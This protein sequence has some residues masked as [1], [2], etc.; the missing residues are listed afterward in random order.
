MPAIVKPRSVRIII[1]SLLGV[2]VIVRI[3]DQRVSYSYHTSDK[4][5]V[6]AIASS[7]LNHNHSIP[8]F[9]SPFGDNG[10][11]VEVFE[12]LF[13]LLDRQNY[14]SF[15]AIAIYNIFFLGKFHIMSTV[16]LSS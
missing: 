9:R 1:A 11:I 8:A 12:E 14:G 16:S 7:L 2:A 4:K 3:S 5:R 6:L 13:V 10:K 15:S